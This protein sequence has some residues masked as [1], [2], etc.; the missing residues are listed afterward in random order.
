M[1]VLHCFSAAKIIWK[2]QKNGKPFFKF[3]DFRDSQI[4]RHFRGKKRLKI[5]TFLNFYIHCVYYEQC[6]LQKTD[7]GAWFSKNWAFRDAF[8]DDTPLPHRAKFDYAA[9]QKQSHSHR[10]RGREIDTLN[11]GFLP[12]ALRHQPCSSC[13]AER[14]ILPG[15]EM[16]V[17]LHL[18]SWGR[19]TGSTEP[20]GRLAFPERRGGQTRDIW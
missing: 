8:A 19:P 20:T 16:C 12:S 5:L 6:V 18:E 7:F 13:I 4:K 14:N 11:V 17:P 2:N 10:H 15:R 3:F 9:N 1:F